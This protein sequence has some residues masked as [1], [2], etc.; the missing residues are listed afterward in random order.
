MF[1]QGHQD[2]QAKDQHRLF[3]QSAFYKVSMVDTTNKRVKMMLTWMF[4]T[5][6]IPVTRVSDMMGGMVNLIL[7]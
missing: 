1:H 5:Y 7:N 2:E 6:T 4:V 3:L